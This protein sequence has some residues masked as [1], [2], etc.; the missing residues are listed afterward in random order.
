MKCVGRSYQTIQKGEK[1]TLFVFHFPF[2]YKKNT[3][4][5]EVE[6]NINEQNHFVHGQTKTSEITIDTDWI[7]SFDNF[8]FSME[9]W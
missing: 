9:L 3:A 6:R 4:I 2:K 5:D 1:L 8:V 7:I